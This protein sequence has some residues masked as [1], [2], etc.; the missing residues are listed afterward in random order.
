[1]KR[2]IIEIDDKYSDILSITAVGLGPGCVDVS[3]HAVNL[4]NC[5]QIIIDST[6][7]YTV[8]EKEEEGNKSSKESSCAETD[9]YY[10]ED[11]ECMYHNTVFLEEGYPE[12]DA[13]TGKSCPQYNV[14]WEVKV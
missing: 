6:G 4:D 7:T 10:N 14:D 11:H 2:V 12:P 1:M 5:E 9:C 13:S 8:V 3:T